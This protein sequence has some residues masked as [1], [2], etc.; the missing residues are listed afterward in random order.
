MT[1]ALSALPSLINLLMKYCYITLRLFR[2]IN[3]THMDGKMTE[4]NQATKTTV[5]LNLAHKNSDDCA[6]LEKILKILGDR[7]NEKAFSAYRE[8]GELLDSC[9]KRKIEAER[10]ESDGYFKWP[11]TDAPASKF[12]FDCENYSYNEGLLS[13]VGYHVGNNG[14]NTYTRRKILDCVFHNKL[15]RVNSEE[16]MNEWGTEETPARLKKMAD[17]LATFIRDKKRNSNDYSKSIKEWESDLDYLYEKYYVGRF[18]FDW[19]SKISYI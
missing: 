4:I 14:K 18:N 19:P 7:K 16:Y 12:G 9:K 2:P 1:I 6:L 8:I 15:P 10:R 11:T 5:L 3:A 13:F 17:C